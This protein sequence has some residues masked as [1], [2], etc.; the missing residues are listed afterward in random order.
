MLCNLACSLIEHRQIR[1]TLAKA[2]A[3]R[4][5]AEKLVT[6]GKRDSIH[7]RRRADSLLGSSTLSK[8]VVKILFSE[9]APASATRQGGYC[10]ITKLGQRQSDSASMAYISWVDFVVETKED[11]ILAEA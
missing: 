6:L 1:T 3:L 9:L 11:E 2:K 8:R 7:A 10:R 5:F 4:P